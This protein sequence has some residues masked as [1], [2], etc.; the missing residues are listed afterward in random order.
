MSPRVSALLDRLSAWA[1]SRHDIRAAALVGSWARGRPRPDSDLDVVILTDSPALYTENERWPVE[2]GLSPVVQ[3]R[4]WGAITE[5]RASAGDLGVEFGI[6]TPVWAESRPVDPGT[7]RVASDGLLI[8][9]D[10]RHLLADLLSAISASDIGI[11]AGVRTGIP[12]DAAVSDPFDVWRR[13]RAVEGG[14]VTLIDLY[15]L[16]ADRRGLAAHELPADERAALR[17]L[18]LPIM[19]PGYQVAVGSERAEPDPIEIVAYDAGWPDLFQSWRNRLAAALGPSAKRIEHVGSTAV[20]G[21]GAKPVIDIQISVVD[22]ESEG[23][24][25]PMIEGLGVQLRSKDDLHRFFRPFSGL[26][27]D[28]QIHVCA[29][30]SAWER[31]HLLFRDYLRS[32]ETARDSYLVAKLEAARRWRDDRIAYADAKT[33]VIDRLMDQAE[34]W[35][36]STGWR[37]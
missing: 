27:R 4:T 19:W 10:P 18:A 15:R 8:L 32:S 12:R 36:G 29:T 5:Q 14:A 7:H 25:T 33:E 26:P 6:G 35:A 31:R 13:R 17:D 2:L 37:P 22:P 16:V 1:A 24:Y 28:V 11:G 21:L 9:Y 20:P 3:Q 30:G 34:I 23:S